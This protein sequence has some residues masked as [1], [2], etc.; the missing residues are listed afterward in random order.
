MRTR[1]DERYV[2]ACAVVSGTSTR[3]RIDETRAARVE[4]M[5][6]QLK[7]IRVRAARKQ[8]HLH[9]QLTLSL[10]PTRRHQ[11]QTNVRKV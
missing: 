3:E 11:L 6:K 2:V 4:A 5:S 1:V 9:H 7:N 10:A 8:L